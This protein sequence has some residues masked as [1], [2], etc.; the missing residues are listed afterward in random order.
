M[1]RVHHGSLLGDVVEFRIERMRRNGKDEWYNG[2][3][4][5]RDY[6]KAKVF[7]S[8][9]DVDPILKKYNHLGVFGIFK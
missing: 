1:V 6:Y 3:S 7:Y 2:N 5:T 8:Y 4:W 9:K